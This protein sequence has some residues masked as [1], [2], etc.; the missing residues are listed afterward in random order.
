MIIDK[1]KVTSI[2]DF[3]EIQRIEDVETKLSADMPLLYWKQ[4]QWLGMMVGTAQ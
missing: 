4:V 2:D 3:V 1:D